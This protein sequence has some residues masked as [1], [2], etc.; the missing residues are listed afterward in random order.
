MYYFSYLRNDKIKSFGGNKLLKKIICLSVCFVLIL[1]QVNVYCHD[2]NLS[3]AN[4]ILIDN[5]SGRVLIEKYAHRQVPMASLTK[6]M[7]ALIALENGNLSKKVKIDRDCIDIE[8]SSIY[9]KEDEI[10]TL[11]D[12]LYGLMLRSG[13]DAAMA[14]A[15]EIGGSLEGFTDM[16]NLKAKKINALNTSFKNPHGLG[17]QG[18]YSTAYD[19]SLITREALKDTTFRTIFSSKSYTANR[20]KD[21]FFLNKNKTLW[22]YEGGDGGKTGY[23]MEAGRCLVSTASKNQMQLIAICLNARNWFQDNYKLFSYGFENFKP[24]IIYN[25]NQNIYKTKLPNS[26]NDLF[27]VTETDFVYPL[28]PGEKED[29]K[30]FVVL[31]RDIKLPILKGSNMGMIETY[32]NGVLIKKANLIAKD[33]VYKENI[34]KTIINNF[35]KIIN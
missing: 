16:M 30:N 31:N 33:N 2:L 21:N 10:L 19:L 11:E 9:L 32:L 34:F 7:T 28:K 13:N 24:Y 22:E 18:H 20:E 15:K 1:F 23:T 29:I 14:I 4:Y 35:T 5:H 6:I 17:S 8:G 27:I 25:K 26:K 3:G 12:L